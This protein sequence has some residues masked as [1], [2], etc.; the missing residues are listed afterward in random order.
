M[1]I[2]LLLLVPVLLGS[3]FIGGG[4]TEDGGDTTP[5]PGADTNDVLRG[6]AD[7]NSIGGGAG[8]DLI[9]GYRGDDTLSGDAGDDLVDGGLGDDLV[10]GGRGDDV[11]VGA[12]GDDSLQGNGG[13]D[14]LVGGAGN[15]VLLGSS[16][17][18]VLYGGDGNDVLDGVAPT[19]TFTLQSALNIDPGEFGAALRAQVGSGVTDA[20]ARRFVDDVISEDGTLGPDV[21]FGGAGND[22]LTGNNGDTLSG[23]DGNDSFGLNW[24]PGNAPVSI[25][26]YDTTLQA[27]TLAPEWIRVFVDDTT[28]VDPV[29]GLRDAADGMSTEILVGLNVVATLQGVS[30]A[31]VDLRSIT[32]RVAG[33][34][35]ITDAIRL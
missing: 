7:D 28:I 8:E 13:D 12:A 18:D 27:D 15:D 11:L 30:A 9:F 23:D 21:L 17:A 31:D 25:T 33:S 34:D 10:L 19:D 32:M 2:L 4:G 35:A 29:L 26:D 6:T 20:D 16:G 22:L 14:L 1:E 3:L 24:V 5:E